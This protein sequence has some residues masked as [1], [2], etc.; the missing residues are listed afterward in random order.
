[1]VSLFLRSR[2]FSTVKVAFTSAEWCGQ[3]YE[4]AIFRPS[5]SVGRGPLLLRGRVESLPPPRQ[6]ARNRR[7]R[8]SSPAAAR[9]FLPPGRTRSVH[10]LTSLVRLASSRTARRSGRGRRGP[11]A[12]AAARERAGGR[13]PRHPLHGASKTDAPDCSGSRPYPHRVLKWSWTAEGRRGARSGEGQDEG[14]LL[15]STRSLLAP[16]RPRGRA[17]SRGDGPAPIDSPSAQRARA[18]RR[19]GGR[20]GPARAVPPG[21]SDVPRTLLRHVNI[22]FGLTLFALLLIGSSPIS[23]SGRSSRTRTA[24]HTQE[25]MAHAACVGSLLSDAE[26]GQGFLVTGDPIYLEP[27][28]TAS[29]MLRAE[30]DSLDSSPATARTSAPG[31]RGPHADQPPRHARGRHRRP[32]P[33]RG[34]AGAAVAAQR[35][36]ADRH[37]RDGRC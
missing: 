11:R 26:T 6:A 4:E 29:G 35:P 1:M 32:A 19:P 22:G 2:D 30:V 27:H 23:R 36:R 31:S 25:V 37:G 12:R 24:V 18:S 34:R 33:G 3:V 15:R 5:R 7:G 14:E 21:A 13:L 28:T 10:L 8:S 9:D 17:E 20:R 16:E